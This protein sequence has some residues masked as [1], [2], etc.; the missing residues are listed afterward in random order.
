M[1]CLKNYLST[2]IIITNNNKDRIETV[3]LFSSFSKWLS[4]NSIT[5]NY[6]QRSFNS[7]MNDL[8][9]KKC[10]SN[11][12]TFF[13]GLSYI[14]PSVIPKNPPLSFTRRIASRILDYASQAT[15]IW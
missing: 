9:F 7:Y 1:N 13:S 5:N 10:R 3:K 6:N 4:D 14:V 8:S 2:F 11:G 12:K 15:L